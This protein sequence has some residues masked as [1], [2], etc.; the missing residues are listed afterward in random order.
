MKGALWM[1]VGKKA[2]HYRIAWDLSQF[3]ENVL[4]QKK[5]GGRVNQSRL[6]ALLEVNLNKTEK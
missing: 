6:T 3:N 1:P 2:A 4:N 5:V